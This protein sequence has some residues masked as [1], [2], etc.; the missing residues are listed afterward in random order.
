MANRFFN[1][2]AK[3]LIAGDSS[4][5]D[6]GTHELATAI[7]VEL[8]NVTYLVVPAHF[9]DKLNTL[10]RHESFDVQSVTIWVNV[11][12]Q[13]IDL[14]TS[15]TDEDCRRY[16]RHPHQDIGFIAITNNTLESLI[17]FGMLP[18]SREEV[19]TPEDTEEHILTGGLFDTTK[20][21]TTI[22]AE[23]NY[24]F[25]TP[26]AIT[27]IATFVKFEK[28][29]S[30]GRLRFLPVGQPTGSRS[31]EGSSGGPIFGGKDGRSWLVGLQ[32]AQS[33]N[34]DG[35]IK[36]LYAIDVAAAFDDAIKEFGAEG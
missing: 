22:I 31:F 9:I 6:M 7:L 5:V 35:S 23:P 17:E 32:S 25:K 26:I 33:R 12:S 1:R 14:G 11:P 36:N 30:E 34:T 28:R 20:F 3:I 13:G 15:L 29:D 16:F 19:S 27:T 10:V 8:G 4:V 24:Y 2:F 21:K 18:F